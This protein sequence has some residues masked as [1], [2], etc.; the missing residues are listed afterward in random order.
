MVK[1]GT[2]T[3]L[4]ALQRHRVYAP[5]V[6]AAEVVAAMP[7]MSVDESIKKPMQADEPEKVVV[8]H[9]PTDEGEATSKYPQPELQQAVLS[10][11]FARPRPTAPEPPRD[12]EPARVGCFCFWRKKRT[13]PLGPSI[14]HFS[15]ALKDLQAD[16]G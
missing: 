14:V 2:P 10:A 15:N 13:E 7:A 4:M 11:S 5:L 16:F 8:Q 3:K 9:A 6:D 12:R 1:T